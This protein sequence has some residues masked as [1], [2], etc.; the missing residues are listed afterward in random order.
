MYFRSTFPVS[1]RYTGYAIFA[2]VHLSV[3]HGILPVSY[4]KLVLLVREL[5]NKSKNWDVHE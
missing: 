3:F 4:S 1:L 2:I 5:F